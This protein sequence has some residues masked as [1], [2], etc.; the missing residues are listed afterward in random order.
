MTDL[1]AG[2]GIAVESFPTWNLRKVVLAL[3][4]SDLFI[5]ERMGFGDAVF[6]WR[7]LQAEVIQT[8]LRQ[9]WP[10]RDMIGKQMREVAKSF[11]ALAWKNA[12]ILAPYL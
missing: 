2:E 11:R 12:E 8:A 7:D 3:V 10:R 4:R 1:M 5:M 9:L 6:D